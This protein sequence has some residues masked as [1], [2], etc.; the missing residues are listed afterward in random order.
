V[1][2]RKLAADGCTVLLSSHQLG[3]VQQI[4]DRVG[5]IAQGR[6]VAETT[7]ADLGSGGTLRLVVEPIDQATELLSP[8]I[9]VDRVQANGGGLDLDVDPDLASR[10]NAELVRAGMSVSELRWRQ[11]DL[12]QTFLELT[13]G[14]AH[15]E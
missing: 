4:C 12:E 5:V 13:G 3:E 9:G 15:V 2:I 10:I 6:L 8:L 11:P 7:V 1:T 14:L